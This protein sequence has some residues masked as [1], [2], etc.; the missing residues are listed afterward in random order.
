VPA[1]AINQVAAVL[2]IATA[3]DDGIEDK[4]NNE[5]DEADDDE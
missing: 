2:G 1:H 4:S 5:P 3:V